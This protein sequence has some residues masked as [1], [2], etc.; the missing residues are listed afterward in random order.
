MSRTLFRLLA[1]AT[2]VLLI[3]WGFLAA[4]E[5]LRWTVFA[6]GLGLALAIGFAAGYLRG[7]RHYPRFTEAVA[8]LAAD[9]PLPS[10]PPVLA[11][12]EQR[13][14]AALARTAEELQRRTREGRLAAERAHFDGQAAALTRLAIGL[15]GR[16]SQALTGARIAVAAADRHLTQPA[17][18]R[19]NRLAE[20]LAQADRALNQA[21][22]LVQGLRE[23]APNQAPPPEPVAIEEWIRR[24]VED[25]RPRAESLAVTWKLEFPQPAPRLP[26]GPET[27]QGAVGPLLDN[28]LDALA[29]R[30]GTITVSL[31]ERHGPV[32]PE[33]EIA[34]QDDGPGLTPSA[35]ERAFDPFFSTRAGGD[36]IGLG[37]VFAASAAGRLG[38]GL[39]L[40]PREPRGTTAV[41]TIPLSRRSAIAPAG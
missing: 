19:L 8:R 3:T 11:E 13:L 35:R 29:E 4:P 21:A 39:V 32:G 33:L 23:L 41:V 14:A 22:A 17:P 27:I 37:L 36:G 6:V 40:L 2:A 38:G 25:R 28:A 18:D 12:Q 26:A 15:A 7:Q 5:E 24:A 30:G 9:S 16:F 34:V 10:W 31:R 1:A 20:D